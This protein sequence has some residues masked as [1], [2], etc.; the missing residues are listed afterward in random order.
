[1]IGREQT[2]WTFS[3]EDKVHSGFK[4]I[5]IGSVVD[6]M[7]AADY[8]IVGY[9]DIIRIERKN[10]FGELFG[11]YSPKTN[12]ERFE[13]EMEKL[14]D[15]KHKYLIIETSLTKDSLCLSVPQFKFGMPA[16]VVMRWL[17]ELQLEYGIHVMFVG[18]A[19]CKTVRNI[20]EEIIKKYG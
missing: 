2:P 11:N 19:G 4:S 8:S 7:D 20:F 1:M 10:G 9:E 16:S 12:R 5:V 18:D 15:V 13:R 14:R 6:S 17:I 3:K